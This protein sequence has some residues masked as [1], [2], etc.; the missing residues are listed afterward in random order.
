MALI[1]SK[2]DENLGDD[3]VLRLITPGAEKTCTAVSDTSGFVLVNN[4]VIPIFMG[5]E[6]GIV[7]HTLYFGVLLQIILLSGNYF[8]S[9][10]TKVAK[11][12]ENMV[13]VAQPG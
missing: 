7:E 5:G 8:R 6:F 1:V 9:H 2:G 11:L 4:L 13:S 3:F 12:Q 10:S